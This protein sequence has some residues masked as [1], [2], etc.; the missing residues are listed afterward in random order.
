MIGEDAILARRDRMNQNALRMK[1]ITQ[2]YSI[3]DA[4]QYRALKPL[5][6]ELAMGLHD[7]YSTARPK[8]KSKAKAGP[9]AVPVKL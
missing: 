6:S 5:K 1:G 4:P 7:N 2:S 3:Y 9:G 8:G